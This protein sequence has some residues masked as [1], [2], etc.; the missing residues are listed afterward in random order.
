MNKKAIDAIIDRVYEAGLD[1]SKWQSVVNQLQSVFP[2][3]AVAL[4]GIDLKANVFTGAVHCGF[5][6]DYTER[7][8]SD[9]SSINPFIQGF[10]TAPLGAVLRAGQFCATE[11]LQKSAYYNDWLLPQAQGGGVAE[12]LFRD[13]TRILTL[14]MNCGTRNQDEREKS[15]SKALEY[16]GPHLQRSFA[17]TRQLAAQRFQGEDFV[18]R[19]TWCPA[20]R[21]CSVP[22]ANPYK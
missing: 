19:W 16:I 8:E 3:S 7:Y 14:T 21:I 6:Q 11:V 12:V 1:V 4:Y 10:Q 5:Y 15:L 22:T 9:Y 20:P 18:P 2:Y 13:A 17:L